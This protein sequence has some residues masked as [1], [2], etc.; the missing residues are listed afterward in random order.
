M[1]SSARMD[2]T[3]GSQQCQLHRRFLEASVNP[4]FVVLGIMKAGQD[5]VTLS[6]WGRDL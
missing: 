6:V 5:W 4:P 3:S 2:Y 1:T